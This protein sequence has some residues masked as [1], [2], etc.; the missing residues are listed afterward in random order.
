V[1]QRIVDGILNEGAWLA[2]SM[3]LSFVAVAVFA[4]ARSSGGWDRGRVLR[5]L[6]V[7]YGALI[8]TM[9]FGHLLAVTVKAAQGVLEPPLW[10]MGLLGLALAVPAWWLAA[11]AWRAGQ[12]GPVS[13]R[14]NVWLGLCLLGLGLHNLPLAAPAAL[15]LAYQFHARRALGWAIVGAAVAA[16][17]ALFAGALAFWASGQTFEQFS[18]R[19]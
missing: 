8:G 12:A 11:R 16:N 2:W 4:R 15:N 18:A 3:A 7:F 17:V 10:A 13:A 9:A 1:R 14:L 19:P 5:A 6:H